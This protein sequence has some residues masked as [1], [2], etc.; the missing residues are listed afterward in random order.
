MPKPFT[1]YHLLFLF[2]VAYITTYAQSFEGWITYKVEMPN[3]NPKMIPDSLWQK[4][5]K[6]KLGERG[7][8]VQKYYYKEGNY[9]S[10]IDAGK[11]RGYQLYNPKDGLLYSWRVGSDSAVTVDSRKTIDTFVE[12]IDQKETATVMG[13][14]CKSM[15]VKSEMGEM[16]V[17]YNKEYL[18]MDA[19][20]YKGHLYG[21]W[22]QILNKIGCMPLKIE[23]MGFMASAVQ[24]VTDFK[25]VPVDNKKF[26]LPK[27][28]KVLKN[29]IN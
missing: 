25:Q 28:K 18:K 7:Y 26:E 15:I 27:F 14:V 12:C 23:Q 3:P 17:W 2:S 1:K 6:E 9:I 24:E 29:P 19:R 8:I 5:L 10:E 22:D 16:K 11:E 21:H 13:I 20:F 4:S